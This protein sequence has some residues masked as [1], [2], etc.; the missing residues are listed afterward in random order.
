MANTL[1]HNNNLEML[2]GT[3][4][5]QAGITEQVHSVQR[6]ARF[7][8]TFLVVNMQHQPTFHHGGDEL[9]NLS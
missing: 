2:A 9:Q 5:R 7:G 6:W 3:G 4:N 1:I 8:K